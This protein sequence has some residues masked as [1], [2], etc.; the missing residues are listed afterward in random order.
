MEK[1]NPDVYKPRE[2]DLHYYPYNNPE[3]RVYL[4][5]EA[6]RQQ[7]QHQNLT[8]SPTSSTIVDTKSDNTSPPTS[9][10]IASTTPSYLSSL[11]YSLFSAEQHVSD[12][13]S[14]FDLLEQLLH[15]ESTKRITPKRALSHPFLAGKPGEE[16][17]LPDD[18]EFVPHEFGKGVCGKLHYRNTGTREMGVRVKAKCE[19][20][21]CEGVERFEKRAV[22]PG[23]GVAI[24]RQ[25][26]EFHVVDL[27]F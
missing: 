9:A 2:P 26:C 8:S 1:L 27:E 6:E 24:G 22:V 3:Y 11:S 10:T 25:P 19:C 14:A 12:V 7:Q 4:Q 21:R 13:D 5:E 23:E 20:G 16:D 17:T 18:D 15:P